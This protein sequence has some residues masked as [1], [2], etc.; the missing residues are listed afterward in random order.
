MA[1]IDHEK[2]R[3]TLAQD[4]FDK[5]AATDE[6]GGDP[7]GV[8]TGVDPGEAPIRPGDRPDGP[9]STDESAQ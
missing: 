3:Q 5:P 2:D 9:E 6:I 7:T 8:M 4:R 1:Q